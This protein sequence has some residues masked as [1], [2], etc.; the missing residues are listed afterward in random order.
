VFSCHIQAVEVWLEQQ[1]LELLPVVVLLECKILVLLM[2]NLVGN[3]TSFRLI[4]VIQTYCSK[5]ATMKLTFDAC[6]STSWVFINVE[7]RKLWLLVKDKQVWMFWMQ[8][9]SLGFFLQT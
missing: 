5:N 4:R 8:K 3:K 6:C 1:A 7:K 2:D 9:Q